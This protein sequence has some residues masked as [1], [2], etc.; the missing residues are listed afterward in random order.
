VEPGLLGDELGYTA[1]SAQPDQIPAS[2]GRLH[3]YFPETQ[4]VVSY[5]FLDYFRRHGGIDTFG[6]PTSDFMYEAGR[7]VQTFQRARMEWHP[8]R[9]IGSQIVLTNLGE[10][11]AER[12]GFPGDYDEP[13]PPPPILDEDLRGTSA[14]GEG[15]RGPKQGVTGLRVS[16]SVGEPVTGRQGTQ[17]LSI[18][19]DDQQGQPV[20]GASVAMVARY[21]SDR[22]PEELGT[23]NESG[24]VSGRFEIL[25][26]PPGE[27][28]IID[29]TAT[30]NDL[31]VTTQT[32]FVT[33][34]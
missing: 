28:I 21:P 5:A 32:F 8:E 19:V 3:H 12:F 27:R 29:V 15:I 10:I 9:Q 16:A 22:Q 14:F 4:R 17:T 23:T 25:P 7:V 13:L 34:W 1:A 30:Y 31:I 26:A 33:W 20:E 18:Y 2:N 11:Y 24:F 6:Y